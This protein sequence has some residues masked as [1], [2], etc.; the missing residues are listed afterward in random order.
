MP[1]RSKAMTHNKTGHPGWKK[2]GV[3]LK[4]PSRKKH[5]CH[6]TSESKKLDEEVK[7]HPGA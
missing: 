7:S 5:Y 6:A 3:E 2:T 1:D 4:A